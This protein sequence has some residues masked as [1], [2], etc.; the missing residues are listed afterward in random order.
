[1]DVEFG[2]S[3]DAQ[4]RQRFFHLDPKINLINRPIDPK[5]WYWSFKADPRILVRRHQ[6][7]NSSTN[8][9][10]YFNKFIFQGPN[11]CSD[12]PVSFH[13]IQPGQMYD[14]DYFFYKVRPY[15]IEHHTEPLPPKIPYVP[16]AVRVTTVA[17]TSKPSQET[18]P[19]QPQQPVNT[20]SS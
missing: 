9:N 2:D 8:Y 7:R 1:M 3:R 19:P 13:Y 17:S 5:Y 6:L 10:S 12:N 4:G 11:C 20:T 16:P 14:L 18:E 15:G